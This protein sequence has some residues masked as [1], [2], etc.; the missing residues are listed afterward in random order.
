VPAWLELSTAEGPR[1]VPLDAE[2]VSIGQHDGNDVPLP[3]DATA[4]RLHAV[5]ERYPSGWCVR[6]LGSRNGTWV[7]GERVW[8]AR[9]LR[10]GDSL[11]LGVTRIVFRSD[12]PRAG[13]RA[14]EPGEPPPVLTRR[15]RDVLVALC[16]PMASGQ[17]FTEPASIRDIAEELVVTEAAVKHHL[18][19][20][21]D[22]FQVMGE[23]GR[24][25]VRLANEAVRRGAIGPGD[26]LAGG[27]GGDPRD[28]A[29]G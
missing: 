18:L 25:R 24:R 10:D 8:Q 11:T 19:R 13:F 28:G 9:P 15:E 12:E 7:N 26:Y 23:E 27:P 29:R 17:V 6:D 2:R 3:P 22:K 14:T 4:S 20:L 21:Y 16:R 5:L 1:R